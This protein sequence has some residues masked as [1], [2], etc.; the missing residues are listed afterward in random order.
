MAG[1]KAMKTRASPSPGPAQTDSASRSG[2]RAADRL[3]VGAFV[4][5]GA[6]GL[7][8]Q[9]AWS[10]DLILVFGDTSEAIG[11][12]VSA[13]MGGLGLGGFAGGLVSPRLRSPLVVYGLA[14]LAVA[15]SALLV[16]VG[17]HLVAGTYASAY[18]TVPSGQLTLLRLVLSFA[19]LTPVTFVMGVT[20]PLLTR[21]L[22][23][24]MQTAGARM[25]QLY[26]ANTLGAMGGT[27]AAGL[28]LI[29]LV[30]LSAT[31]HVAVALNAGVGVI[32]LVLAGRAPAEAR[33]SSRWD[34]GRGAGSSTQRARVVFYVV[35]FISGFVALA[36][37]VLW[38]RMLAEGTGSLEY[39]FVAILAVFLLG[40]GL[41]GF[42]YRV[43][44][45]PSRDS[46]TCLAVVFAL[47]AASTL[48]TVPLGSIPHDPVPLG[49]I[50]RDPFYLLRVLVLVPPTLAMGYAFPLTARL[51]TREVGEGG[52]SIGLLYGWNTIGSILG[53]L[54]A[55][56]ILAATLGT[57]RSILLLSAAAALAGLLLLVVEARVL[58]PRSAR[59]DA[60]WAPASLSVALVL[61]PTLLVGSGSSLSKT[62]TEHWLDAHH[63]PY[64]HVE[65]RLS[66]V[67][68]VGGPPGQGRLEVS[69]TAMTALSVDTNLMAYLPKLVRPGASRFLDVCFGMGT[70]YRSAINLGMQVDAVDLS[71]S[72]SE[73]MPTFFPDAN[74]YLH[75]PSGHII[76][77]D[78][79]NYVKLTPKRYDIISVDP[80]PP[81][82]SA[83]AGILYTREFYADAHR[84]LHRNGV[85]LQWLYYA[86]DVSELREHL[87]TFRSVFPHVSVLLSPLHGG[88]Y[89]LGSDG[90]LGWDSA[91]ASRVLGSA[92]A[93]RDLRTA[94]DYGAIAGRPWPQILAGMRWM[95]DGEVDRFAGSAPLITD[96]RPRT[97]YY[98]LHHL[99]AARDDRDVTEA[100]L[101][102][103]WP[104]PPATGGPG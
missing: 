8:Y 26:G 43:L 12:I 77:A 95:Q 51:L 6:A 70:T 15:A 18:G 11:T 91:T 4:A 34:S 31:A 10:H 3:V 104:A 101:R 9:V 65:D 41:G 85:M 72:V 75:S 63:L 32:G 92:Q 79:R 17:L 39:H 78:G 67:D 14:E 44:S 54:S 1:L 52:R 16:P 81:L 83:G 58:R 84:A 71:P 30:G 13:F 53:S 29:E 82:H 35:T 102:K 40:I 68:A 38:T 46:A 66:T 33:T 56:F 25:G 90:N 20:L 47:L 94:P 37:E 24:S 80:P 88:L 49:S 48:V 19:V 73:Q 42:A 100:R 96:D 36:L 98:I 22:V 86:V 64:Q 62:S 61:L 93:T 99:F 87:H 60:L 2:S 23:T 69:G 50:P 55:T 59:R 57:N 21:H 76:T 5:S 45:R 89:M 28:V 103:L 7:T 74:R 27:L 97:E